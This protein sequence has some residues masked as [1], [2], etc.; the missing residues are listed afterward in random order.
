MNLKEWGIKKWRPV[1]RIIP[2]C[3]W[4]D[5]GSL[6]QMRCFN[7]LFNDAVICD[8]IWMNEWMNPYRALLKWHWEGK[9]AIFPRKL[10]QCRFVHRKPH[11]KQ[12]R[13]RINTGATAQPET[14]GSRQPVSRPRS[15]IDNWSRKFDRDV[16]RGCVSYGGFP[17]VA[18]H[19]RRERLRI[20]KKAE[21]ISFKT[22]Y[23]K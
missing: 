19:E 14:T 17:E 11:T 2:V 13:R 3:A 15:N 1:L 4:K 10:L 12:P 7:W 16:Q 9:I 5:W 20:W 21:V 8:T 6:W 22:P 23:Q 18:E